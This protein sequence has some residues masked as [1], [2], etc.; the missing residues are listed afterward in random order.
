MDATCEFLWWILA[1]SI[2]RPGRRFVRGCEHGSPRG[3]GQHEP[4]E[5]RPIHRIR[6]A[7]LLLPS[8]FRP[9]R[10]KR[11]WLQKTLKRSVPTGSARRNEEADRGM[12]LYPP[13]YSLPRVRAE[14]T[15]LPHLDPAVC[16]RRDRAARRIF[17]ETHD[18]DTRSP[19]DDAPT[20]RAGH[21]TIFPRLYKV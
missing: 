15:H 17:P 11:V 6:V 20:P 12:R 3:G 13:G 19:S 18:S 5:R 7:Y 10:M 16:H 4:S 9:S 14:D 1:R 8:S 21:E 2:R